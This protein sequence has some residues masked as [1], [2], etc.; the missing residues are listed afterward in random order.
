MLVKRFKQSLRWRIAI[1]FSGL[2]LVLF[3]TALL[4]VNQQNIRNA[5]TNIESDLQVTVGVFRRLI[6]SRTQSLQDIARPATSDHAFRQVF[7]EGHAPTLISAMQNLVSRITNIPAETMLLVDFDG[8]I[9]AS[10]NNK[11]LPGTANPWPWLIDRAEQ[12]DHLEASGAILINGHPH[13]VIISPLLIP[14]PEAWVILGFAIDDNF[15]QE[16]ARIALT[17]ISVYSQTDAEAHK[18]HASSLRGAVRNVLFEDISRDLLKMGNFEKEKLQKHQSL[19]ESF[20]SLNI[21]LDKTPNSKIGVAIH[22]S[23]DRELEPYEQLN[24]ALIIIFALGF[25][26]SAIGTFFISRSITDPIKNLS[27]SVA[28]I[29]KGNYAAR[30]TENRED[31]IGSLAKTV[32]IMAE[33]LE[34]KETVRNLLGKVVSNAVAE[35]LLSNKIELGGEEREVS[36]LFSDIRNFTSLSETIPPSDLLNLL[37]RYFERITSVIDNQQGIV[38]KYI[39]DAVMAVFGAPISRPDH[40]ELAVKT[41]LD[42]LDALDTFNNE[43]KDELGIELVCGIGINSGRAV[44]GNMGSESRMNYTLVGDTVNLASRLEELTKTYNTPILVSSATANAVNNIEWI[45]LGRAK[46]KGKSGQVQIFKPAQTKIS[47]TI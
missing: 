18:L 23:L 2:I 20:L 27:I 38:D 21:E 11:F 47:I 15:A 40:A 5:E 37:N 22:G 8:N 1:L 3:T 4:V 45:D 12:D 7:G 16:I 13:Q 35:E 14:D 6:E 30:A 26:F 46:V 28:S 25:L 19:D 31:E 34:E 36:I 32:N 24:I 29:G 10:T 42:M 43:I 44:A 9:I 17:H 39:G 41:A 33:G